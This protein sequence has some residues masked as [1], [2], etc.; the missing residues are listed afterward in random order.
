M[1]EPIRRSITVECSPERAFEVFTQQL[2]RWWPVER[3]SLAAGSDVAVERIVMEPFD[4]GRIFEVQTGGGEASWGT[5]LTWDPPRRLV[6][7]WKP[8]TTPH[9]PTE[10]EIR[11]AEGLDGLTQVELEHRGWERLGEDATESHAS[12]AQGWPLV[13]DQLFRAACEIAS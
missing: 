8:N 1:I 5:V 2:S 4:G 10:V 3:F 9:P 6:M 7:A 12:Y 11:F 13:F